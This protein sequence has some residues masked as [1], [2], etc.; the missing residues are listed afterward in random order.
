[1]RAMLSSPRFLRLRGLSPWM[2]LGMALI[3]GAAV[4]VLSV[5]SSQ[6]E[7]AAMIHNMVDRAEALIWALEAAAL[8]LLP[9]CR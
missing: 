6:R 8:R 5:R 4:T 7:R 3:L 9:P 1:M 2:L